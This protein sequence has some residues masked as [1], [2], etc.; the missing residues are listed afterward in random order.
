MIEIKKGFPPYFL[1]DCLED[2][3]MTLDLYVREI[4]FS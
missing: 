2:K 4:R 3:R 1:L